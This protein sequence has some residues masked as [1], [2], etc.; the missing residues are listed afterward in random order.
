MANFLKA[1]A[2][3]L[4]ATGLVLAMPAAAAPATHAAPAAHAA[5]YGDL[6]FDH[7]K[8]DKRWKRD[9]DHYYGDRHDYRDYRDRRDYRDYRDGR[10]Y[11]MGYSRSYGQPVYAHTRIWRGDDG[12]YYCRRD[13]GTTG[14]LVGAGVGALIGH[15]VVGRGG[16]RTLGAILGGVAGA[17]LGRSIDRSNTRCG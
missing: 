6:S 2:L 9:R 1:P 16:D 13:N 14:L 11:Y 15:E 12:R 5:V 10:P 7:G 4:A 8:K 3:A 17:L